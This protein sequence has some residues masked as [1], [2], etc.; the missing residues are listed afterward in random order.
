MESKKPTGQ[1]TPKMA[2]A[3]ADLKKMPRES[4]QR[5]MKAFLQKHP[6]PTPKG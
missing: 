4:R 2:Q 6:R 3:L 1:L 5:V